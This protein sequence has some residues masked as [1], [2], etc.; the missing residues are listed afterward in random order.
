MIRDER[1][2]AAAILH[3][4]GRIFSL[5]P[6]NRH[7]DVIAHMREEGA[8][9]HQDHERGH[10]QGFLTSAGRF[11]RRKPAKVIAERAGQLLPRAGGT[12]ALFSEDVW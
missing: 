9:G 8:W 2:V 6:P 10:E 5:P 4:D 7:N 3:V 1:I 12:P 11:V